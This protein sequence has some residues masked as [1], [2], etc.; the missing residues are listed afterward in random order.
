[1]S[2]LDSPRALP[3]RALVA[4]AALL[5]WAWGSPA[6]VG[7][8]AAAAPKS[9][10]APTGGICQTFRVRPQDQ[11]WVVNTRWLGCPDGGWKNAAGQPAWTLWKYEP[12]APRWLNATSAEFYAADSADVV[13][14]VY[15]HGNRIDNSTALGEGLDVYFQLAGKFDD[16]RPVRFVIWSWP[17][18]Q[19]RGPL[20]DVRAKAAR[21]DTEAYYLAQFLAGM[22]PQVKTGLLGYSLGARIIAGGLHLLGGGQLCG[23]MVP[24]GERP[25]MQVAFWAAAEHDNWL[26]PGYH[27]GQALGMA[28]HWFITHNCCDPVLARYRFVEKHGSPA[29]MGYAGVYGRNLL[30]AELNARIEEMNVTNLVGGS[31]DLGRYLY[32][33][34]I[35]DRTRQGVLWHAQ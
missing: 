29:A 1:M 24:P 19:I 30:P 8:E 27:H 12:L 16:E 17:S 6:L 34:P 11:V 9:A 26:L 5:L 14:A 33:S 32:C 23:W 7:A 15:I 20:R 13:T 18:D 21:S 35:I 10:A 22:Q 4:L 2:R 3:R 31:H 28:G 25:Q